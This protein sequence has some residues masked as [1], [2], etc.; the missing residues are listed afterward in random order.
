[1]KE[2]ETYRV[3]QLGG[4][5]PLLMHPDFEE[6][7]AYTKEFV[8]QVLD[9]EAADAYDALRGDYVNTGARYMSMIYPDAVFERLKLMARFSSAW[10]YLDDLM[11]NSLDI[12]RVEAVYDRFAAAVFGGIDGD[13]ICQPVTAFFARTD[14]H[15]ELRQLC[16]EQFL[17]Y[18]RAVKS[19]RN[20]EINRNPIAVDEYLELRA[21]NC[22]MKV[23]HAFAGYMTADLAEAWCLAAR[24]DSYQRAVHLSGEAQGI[25]LDLYM[26]NAERPEI[27][28]WTRVDR[29]IQR[30]SR[31]KAGRQQ[32][33]DTAV[34][35]FNDRNSRAEREIAEVASRFP[36]VAAAMRNVH[37]STL[38]YLAR[39][40][41]LRYAIPQP[42]GQT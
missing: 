24:T 9:V 36:A 18:L 30:N 29:V 28:E 20:I 1:M 17:G 15:P 25:V 39:A 40:R 12:A 3:P 37:R 7:R 34:T 4:S 10:T 35:L 21:P 5:I 2:R 16:T 19:M 32:A 8:D 27:T 11:D 23:L 42:G 14:W 41:G 6:V 31:Q 26:V 22:A 13:L 38:V 33:I